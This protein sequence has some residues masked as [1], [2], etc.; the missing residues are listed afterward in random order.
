MNKL[1]TLYLFA[2]VALL[3][4]Q[5]LGRRPV[6][7]RYE[8]DGWL[9]GRFFLAMAILVVPFLVAAFA[10][11]GDAIAR[12]SQARFLAMQLGTQV[13]V[14]THPVGELTAGRSV[15]QE[16]VADRDCLAAVG[17]RLATY[18]RVMHGQ[19]K[20]TLKD[21]QGAVVATH[22]VRANRLRDNEFYAFEFPLVAASAQ[23]RYALTVATQDAPTGHAPTVWINR[24]IALAGWPLSIDGKAEAGTLNI[25]LMYAR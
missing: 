9:V 19:V 5:R 18:G 6:P 1:F 11:Q 8:A 24:D 23:R 3:L 4:L 20:F 22:T 14:S 2:P 15:Q 16:F 17:V 7:A 12:N 21:A 25:R 13:E 10:S